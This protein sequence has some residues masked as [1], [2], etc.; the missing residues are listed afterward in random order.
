M[1]G[2]TVNPLLVDVLLRFRMHHIALVAD[3][4]KMYRAIELPSP[5]RDLHRFV[6]CNQSDTLQD[7]RMTRVTF[8]VSFIANMAVKQNAADHAQEFPLAAK[9]VGEASM[10][11]SLE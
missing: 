6:W 10:T 7:Y 11:A 8:G 5:D 1:V 9:V 3:I 4:S 2:P